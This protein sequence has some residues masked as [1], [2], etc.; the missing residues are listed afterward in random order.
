[1]L[2]NIFKRK[3]I[4]HLLIVLLV[5]SV[6]T[7]L[8][9]GSEY[10]ISFED[11]VNN[12]SKFVASDEYRQL[13]LTNSD[14][15]LIDTLYLRAAKFYKGDIS[16]ALLALTFT[17]LPFNRMPI[18][19]P[20]TKLILSLRLPSVN[21]KLFQKK[22][23]N[24]PGIVY[25]DSRLNGSND[26]DKVAHFFGNAFL[27]YNISVLNLSKFF[28]IFVELF[29]SAFKVSGGVDSRDLHTNYLGEFFG[30]SLRKNSKLLPSDFLKVYSLFYFSYTW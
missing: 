13:S 12:L 29:E 22:N 7:S 14:L 10:S 5:F 16:E 9:Q 6:T 8:A 30:N 18:T 25:F 1:L 4:S 20:F 28:G 26:K 17:T 19:I 21:D 23:I 2:N 11:G 24:L 3:F 27:T 15:D